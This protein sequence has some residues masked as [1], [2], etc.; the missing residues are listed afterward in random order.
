MQRFTQTSLI[1]SEIL[2]FA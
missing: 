1:N 2:Q